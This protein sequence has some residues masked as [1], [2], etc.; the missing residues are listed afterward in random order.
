MCTG[1]SV[2][3]DLHVHL[4]FVA[5]YRL[6]V[7][8]DAMLTRCEAV[9]WDVCAGMAVELR[10]FNGEDDHGHLLVHYPPN[11]GVSTLV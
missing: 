10:E 11:L 4:V 8:T 1:K 5:G 2:V 7:L 9:M 6:G 3:Y